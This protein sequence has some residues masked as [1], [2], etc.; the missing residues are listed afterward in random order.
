MGF[1]GVVAA[2]VAGASMSICAALG[3]AGATDPAG[4]SFL[5]FAG[6]DLW[7]DSGF[8]HGGVLWSP[9]GLNNDG[10]A[11]KLLLSGGGYDYF[12]GALNASVNGT[13]VSAAALPGWRIT[14]DG[15]TVTLYAGAA[16]QDYQL[17]P[18]DPGS[19][20]HGPHLGAQLAADIWY[21]PTPATMV[22]VSGTGLS[23]GPTEWTRAAIGWHAF[24]S[25]FVGPE[26]AAF[27]CADYQ[28]WRVGAHLTGWHFATLEWAG[29]A[30]VARD[31][32]R[33]T[34]PYVRLGFNAR[35]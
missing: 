3:P 28:Q 12:S 20:L 35:Y 18:S 32:E 5:I 21:Q 1:R 11:L 13:L 19:R 24:D 7:R 34:G 9:V 6:T 27:W 15:L 14:R 16:A 26:G 2:A 29:G 4:G 33:R 10:F 25:F 22:A 23:I 8:L 17:T 30:G 31:S